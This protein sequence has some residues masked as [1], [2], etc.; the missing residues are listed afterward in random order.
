MLQVVSIHVSRLLCCWHTWHVSKSAATWCKMNV[1]IYNICR[2]IKIWSCKQ[3]FKCEK[4]LHIFSAFTPSFYPQKEYKRVL[5]WKIPNLKLAWEEEVK[6]FLK[7]WCGC[8]YPRHASI[9]QIKFERTYVSDLV[10]LVLREVPQ[11]WARRGTIWKFPVLDCGKIHLQA[12]EQLKISLKNLSTT[13]VIDKS[14]GMAIK[15]H[16]NWKQT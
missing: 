1:F 2:H 5:E 14:H 12:P 16:K 9:E 7:F 4:S 10:N 13:T 6:V 8:N 15:L 11:W 3:I